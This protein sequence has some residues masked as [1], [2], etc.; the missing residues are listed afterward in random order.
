MYT[1]YFLFCCLFLLSIGPTRNLVGRYLLGGSLLWFIAAARGEDI[2]RD[3]QGYLEY[4]NWVTD[5]IVF[6]IEPTFRLIANI[7]ELSTSNPAW[8][9]VVYATLGISIKMLAIWRLTP[10][11]IEAL[12]IFYSGFFFLWDMTQIRGSVA[13]ALILLSV[14]AIQERRLGVFIALWVGASLFHYSALYLGFIYL[15]GDQRIRD[16]YYYIF[17]LAAFTIF[18]FAGA[19]GY[20]VN[21]VDIIPGEFTKAK[22][23]SY[24]TYNDQAYNT[25]NFLFLSRLLLA[26]YLFLNREELSKGNRYFSILLKMYFAGLLTHVALA[27]GSGLGTRLSEFLL[28]VEVVLI[29]QLICLYRFRI[30]GK[31]LVLSAGIA[32]MLF[33]LHYTELLLPYNFKGGPLS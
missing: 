30:F 15:F 27:S 28:V 20:L 4:F 19:G 31:A 6:P 8:I 18:S 25:F 21:F 16:R 24:D 26:I 7:V 29:P 9:F 22:I 13:G 11:R 14:V 2:D 32:F 17:F 33:A 12:L 1:Y 23:L 10:F 3:Y 5:D